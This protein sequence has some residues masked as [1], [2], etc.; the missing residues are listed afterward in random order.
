VA[1]PTPEQIRLAA[2]NTQQ[3]PRNRAPAVKQAIENE[4]HR[5]QERVT[6]DILVRVLQAIQETAAAIDRPARPTGHRC[7]CCTCELLFA[8]AYARGKHRAGPWQ[9]RRCLSAADLELSGWQQDGAG[10]WQ[11]PEVAS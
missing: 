5:P 2:E 11:P 9:D 6:V 1:G 3:K 7:R 8:S 10:S 4:R